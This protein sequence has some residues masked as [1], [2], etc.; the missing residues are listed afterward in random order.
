MNNNDLENIVKEVLK[1][2]QSIVE[3]YKAGKTTT[4]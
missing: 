2:N 1:D 4:L 3:Q